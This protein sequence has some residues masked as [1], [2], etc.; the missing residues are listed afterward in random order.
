MLGHALSFAWRVPKFEAAL[1]NAENRRNLNRLDA[2]RRWAAVFLGG[3]WPRYKTAAARYDG[4]AVLGRGRLT[5][6]EELKRAAEPTRLRLP[7][8]ADRGIPRLRAAI[9]FG[10]RIASLRMRLR[11]VLGFTPSARAAPRSPSITQWACW[12]TCWM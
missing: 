1:G 9:Q 10:L 2:A 4:L 8:A 11:R 5:M 3:D 12:R 7:A 6:D